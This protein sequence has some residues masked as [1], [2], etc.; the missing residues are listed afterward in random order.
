MRFRQLTT[1]GILLIAGC[2]AKEPWRPLADHAA[3][4]DGHGSRYEP[5]PDVLAVEERRERGAPTTQPMQHD[6]GAHADH[7]SAS[8]YPLDTCII[9]GAELG[10][11]GDPVL[12]MYDGIEVR[13]CCAGCI[14][15]FEDDP[16]AYLSALREAMSKQHQLNGGAP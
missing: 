16:E 7:S 5:P 1:L 2:A 6:H 13:F 4:P 10:S 15:V 12:H 11:M 3:N 14:E 9:T 8:H